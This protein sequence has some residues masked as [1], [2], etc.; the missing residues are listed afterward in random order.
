MMKAF[1]LYRPNTDYERSVIEYVHDFTH[2]TQ[3]K[4]EMISLDTREG[5]VKAE[6]YDIVRYPAVIAVDDQGKMLRLWQGNLPLINELSYYTH[7]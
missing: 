1:V 6:L 2:R 5:A 4:L 3:D 7:S